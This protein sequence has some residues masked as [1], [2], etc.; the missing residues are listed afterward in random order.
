MTGRAICSL[1][2]GL[3]LAFGAA[4]VGLA[5]DKNDPT[6]KHFQDLE[7]RFKDLDKDVR[8]LRSIVTQAR[9]TGQPV[10][11][12]LATDPDPVVDG[13]QTHVDDLEQAAKTR[14]DQIDTLTHDVDVA[15][16][17]AADA[18]A[19]AAALSDRLDKLEA[20]LK[21]IDDASAAAAAGGPAPPPPGAAGPSAP[22]PGPPPAADAGAAFKSAKQLLLEGQYASASDAFQ[23]FVETYGDTANGPEA[24]YWLG[25]TLYIRGLYGDAATAYIGAI[26]GWPQTNW[27]PD[28]VVKL[29]RTL[30]ALKKTPEACKTLDEFNRRYPNA[31]PPS[32]ARAAD[33]RAAAKC[34]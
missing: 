21:A 7:K 28:A 17:D 12:R 4:G 14:N 26:R 33:A 9:D 3:T 15:K 18:H 30:V 25:E 8:Q 24:R 22:P 11:V 23:S 1:A 2:L 32:K 10:E 27:A 5:Q 31:S 13:L 6:E 20:R 34:S 19:Q 16:K 29:A